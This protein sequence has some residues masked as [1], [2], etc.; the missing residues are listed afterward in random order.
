MKKSIA[1][2]LFCLSAGLFATEPEWKYTLGKT[3]IKVTAEVPSKEYLYLKNTSVKLTA[4]GKMVLP[5][6]IPDR[7]SVV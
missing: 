6:S 4:D 3:E 7:K 5:A 2:V 1:A